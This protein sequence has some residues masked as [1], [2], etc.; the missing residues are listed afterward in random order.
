MTTVIAN[1]AAAQ[2]FESAQGI[3]G[4]PWIAQVNDAVMVDVALTG[5]GVNQKSS[6]LRAGEQLEVTKDAGSGDLH[7]SF[8]VGGPLQEYRSCSSLV[9]KRGCTATLG[10]Y[11]PVPSTPSVHYRL[12]IDGAAPVDLGE[13]VLGQTIG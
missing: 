2:P 3:V 13:A 11:V 6:Q 9:I 12:L 1:A 10:Y 4:P 8:T 5:S 7:L